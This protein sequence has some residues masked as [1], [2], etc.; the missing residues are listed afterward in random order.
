MGKPI[1]VPGIFIYTDAPRILYFNPEAPD[2]I[3]IDEKYKP[4]LDLVDGKNDESLIYEHINRFYNDE[5]EILTSQIKSLLA[6][7][8][9]FMHNQVKVDRVGCQSISA[10]KQIYLTLTDSCNLA[11]VY[12]YATERKKRDNADF[13][14]WKKY[15]SDIINFAG[16]PVFNFT[17]GEPLTVS[18]ALDL[19]AYIKERGCECL[20]LTNGTFIDTEEIA[21]RIAGLFSMVKI[22]LD[23]NDETVSREL[24]G[25]GV[26]EKAKNAFNLLLARNCNVQIMATVTSKTCQN[27]DSFT[28]AFNNRVQFQ[29][30]YRDIGRARNKEDLSVTGQDYYNALTERG[31][32]WL[33][34]EYH[35]NIHSFRNNPCK[36]CAMANEELSIDAD[37]NV[38][39][40]HMLHFENLVC[41]NLNRESIADIY[42]K[43]AVLNELRTVNVDTIPACKACVFR[44]ICGGACRARV[45]INKYG[46]K[47]HDDFCEFEKK[48]ILD[49]L[50]YSYG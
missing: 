25:A 30:L 3:T 12:C 29:P 15:T 23:T 24:R 9:I 35:D 7:S 1:F 19:A 34:H 28:A 18:Y 2:W 5:K 17:G 21:D 38:F 39:P 33:L 10:P 46:V 31:M 13:E 45:D 27:L 37:G 26:V 14:T 48:S 36:R 32:F 6:E 20:L 42:K 40:C 49:A 16:K 4:I 44:N 43:S 50:L 47:G 8:K 11:C 41:G 22:S